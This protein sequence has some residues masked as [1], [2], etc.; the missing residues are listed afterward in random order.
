MWSDGGSTRSSRPACNKWIDSGA[1]PRF[2][3]WGVQFLR[4]G[5][6]TEQNT[7]GIPSCV[8]CSL[9]RNGSHILIQK[10]W[11]GPS[12]FWGSGVRTPRTSSG[13]ALE[14]TADVPFC[15]A[16]RVRSRCGRRTVE[17]VE[18]TCDD[19]VVDLDHM[20]VVK[21]DRHDRYARDH[22]MTSY[23]VSAKT[24]ESVSR[25]RS[26]CCCC[27]LKFNIVWPLRLVSITGVLAA[28]YTIYC[29][30]INHW[31]S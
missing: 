29:Y 28:S 30:K 23:F 10:S 3:S 5:Y 25:H 9:L 16:G 18:W 19:D 17:R 31:K 24:G 13:C 21:C 8:H 6:C 12:K 22:G 26:P 1:Q 2:Q 20:R 15:G 7:D 14:L 4:L 27:C 11:G